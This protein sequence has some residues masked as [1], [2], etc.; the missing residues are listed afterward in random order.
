MTKPLDFLISNLPS[1]LSFLLKEH[2]NSH[3][4]RLCLGAPVIYTDCV[5][6][7]PTHLLCTKELLEESLTRLTEHSFYCHED[8]VKD[9]YLSLP[10]GIRIG[11]GGRAVCEKSN[12]RSIKDISFICIRIPHTICG[13]ALP[14]FEELNKHRFQTGALLYSLPGVGKTTVLKDLASLL[15]RS[16]KFVAIIDERGEFF[17]CAQGHHTMLYRHYPKKDAITIAAKTATPDLILL[18]E[19]GSDECKTL[20]S[21]ALYGVPVI[22]S[23]HAADPEELL[24]RPGF[25]ELFEH[26]VFKILAGIT[27][28]SDHISYRFSSPVNY[29]KEEFSLK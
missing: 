4:L 26:G 12:I 24:K 14:L 15:S 17:D 13:A 27:R 9:G 22:A 3:E 19:I 21:S 16:G 18:D 20:L 6:R 28:Q 5:G 23:A 11:L 29:P 7:Q 1:P 2:P 8:T 25:K 10:Y